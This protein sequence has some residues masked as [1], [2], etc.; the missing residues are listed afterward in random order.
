MGFLAR[1]TGVA[2][3]TKRFEAGSDAL[4]EGIESGFLNETIGLQPP[5][6]PMER[7]DA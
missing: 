4:A 6:G 7:I 2:V 1:R 5:A 3:A